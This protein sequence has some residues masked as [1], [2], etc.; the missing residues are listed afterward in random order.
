M[1]RAP[2]ESAQ[3][4]RPRCVVEVLGPAG[5]GKTTVIRALRER[6]VAFHEQPLVPWPDKLRVLGGIARELLLAYLREW[7]RSRW[8]NLE[9]LRRMLY[10][11]TWHRVLTQPLAT[12][13]TI[14]ILDHGPIFMLGMVQ[15]FGPKFVRSQHFARWLDAAIE[16]WSA[17]LDVVLWLDA[18]DSTLI[19]R[20]DLRERQHIVKGKPLREA[21]VFLER[22]RLSFAQTLSQIAVRGRLT[23]LRFDTSKVSA[24]DIVEQLLQAL[25]TPT[26]FRQDRHEGDRRVNVQCS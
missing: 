12:D 25:G 6:R 20:I 17:A 7:P 5:A 3:P 26:C 23:V 1:N 10:V 22:C 19:R 8:F 9:E 13:G 16:A 24:N 14:T 21:C 18:P 15:E 2:L 4:P 11:K